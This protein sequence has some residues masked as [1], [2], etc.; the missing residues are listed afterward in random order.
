[1]ARTTETSIDIAAPMA[2]V[3]A[4]LSDVSRWPEWTDSVDSVDL[5]GDALRVG[6]AARV[7]Q[8]K[9]PPATWR[10]TEL[11]PGRSFTWV[12][13]APGLTSAG[14]HE[15]EEFEGVTS[16]RLSLRQSGP[17]A[18]LMRLLIGRLT[19]RYVE[20]EARGLKQRSEA[21]H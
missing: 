3:W 7:K 5:D 6:S 10:V 18:P 4:V 16:A 15:L 2:R 11:M 14:S 20:M 12:A 19:E 21:G 17:L 13:R 8:P 1:V 9:L